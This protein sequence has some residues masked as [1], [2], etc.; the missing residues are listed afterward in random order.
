MLNNN[1]QKSTVLITGASGFIGQHLSLQLKQ[2]KQYIVR[3]AVRATSTHIDPDS[4]D[5]LVY[6]KDIS[7]TTDWHDALK[8]CDV[9]IHLAAK[10]HVMQKES[11]DQ[12]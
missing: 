4:Y 1:T 7:A 2:D 8:N 11:Q 5:E 6:I 10:V 9:V 3:V 12:V